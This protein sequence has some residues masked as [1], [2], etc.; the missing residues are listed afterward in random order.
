MDVDLVEKLSALLLIF[1]A[2]L[3]DRAR[4]GWPDDINF[5]YGKPKWVSIAQTIAKFSYGSILAMLLTE[6]LWLIAVAGVTWKFG[7]QLAGDFGGAFRLVAGADDWLL[8]LE[9]FPCVARTTGLT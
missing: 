8:P 1:S 5:P 7:E 6:N 3:C 9:S 2:C 4:G